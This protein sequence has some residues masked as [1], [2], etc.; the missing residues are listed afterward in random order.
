MTLDLQQGQHAT[1]IA[2]WPA[3]KQ[4]LPALDFLPVNCISIEYILLP[5]LT[6]AF[7]FMIVLWASIALIASM[8][9]VYRL[10]LLSS[11]RRSNAQIHL[12]EVHFSYIASR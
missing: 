11:L 5:F 9:L 3:S 7:N 8:R 4:M 10:V 1:K 2:K 12:L 6:L